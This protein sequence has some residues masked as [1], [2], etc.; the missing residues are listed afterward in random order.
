MCERAGADQEQAYAEQL[1][2]MV[3][4][5]EQRAEALREAAGEEGPALARLQAELAAAEEQQRR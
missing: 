2:T 5:A 1:A 4:E 3:G